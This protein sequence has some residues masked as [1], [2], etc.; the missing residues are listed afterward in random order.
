[1]AIADVPTMIH[2]PLATI[3]T[4]RLRQNAPVQPSSSDA[5]SHLVLI[6]SHPRASVLRHALSRGSRFPIVPSVGL[7]LGIGGFT[8]ISRW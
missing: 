3:E 2:L 6:R 5:L 4:A 8:G 1:M 7:R